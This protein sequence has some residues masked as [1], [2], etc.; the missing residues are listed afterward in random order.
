MK[1]KEKDLGLT[2]CHW[3]G[4]ISWMLSYNRRGSRA[5]RR[6]NLWLSSVHRLPIVGVAIEGDD[7]WSDLGNNPG[8]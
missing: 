6:G 7:S 1:L 4:N 8:V 5:G 2:V 3:H